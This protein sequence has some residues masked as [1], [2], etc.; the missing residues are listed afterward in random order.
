MNMLFKKILFINLFIL[1]LLSQLP[2]PARGFENENE[3]DDWY[4][5][6]Y[7]SPTPEKAVSALLYYPFSSL[8]E[9]ETTRD[10]MAV[11][12]ATI[13]KRNKQLL[14]TAYQEV[15]NN[16]S[17]DIKQFFLRILWWVNSDDSK[18]ILKQAK[19]DWKNPE[20]QEI[21]DQHLS[22]I[23]FDPLVEPVATPNHLDFL[24]SIF[25]ATGEELPL[26]CIISALELQKEKDVTL[27]LTGGAAQ[28]SLISNARQHQKVYQICEESYKTS[29]GFKKESL[30]KILEDAKSK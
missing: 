12:L 15:A 23:P 8:Y 19:S 4:T 30:K 9:K 2:T 26:V 16:P 29:E 3:I 27:F 20:W 11:F 17:S 25:L 24:W 6:Y 18:S 1:T 22:Q 21:I 10:Q 7:Q 5:H 28:W 13:F 14:S